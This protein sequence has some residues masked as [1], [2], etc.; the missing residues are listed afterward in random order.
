MKNTKCYFSESISEQLTCSQYCG[1]D[2]YGF[3]VIPCPSFPCEKYKELKEKNIK[4]A[5]EDSKNATEQAVV[6]DKTAPEPSS[7]LSQAFALLQKCYDAMPK[8]E[9]SLSGLRSDIFIWLSS[10]K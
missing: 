3:A 8:G 2:D 4:I 7:R 10:I 9:G 6:V 5:P 1:F